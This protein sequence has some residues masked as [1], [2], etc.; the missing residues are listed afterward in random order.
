LVGARRDVG[1]AVSCTVGKDRAVPAPNLATTT[2]VTVVIAARNAADTVSA[3]V[4]SA[5]ASPLVIQCVVV[6]DA[7]DD[8]TAESA[9]RAGGTDGRLQ[10][11]RR[12]ERGGP[13]RARNDGLVTAH[14]GTVCFLDADDALLAGGLEQLAAGLAARRGAVA[15]LGRFRAVDAARAPVDVGSWAV[16]QLRPVL[17]R[18]GAMVASPEGMVPEALVSRL[19]S[20]PPGAWLVDA[21]TARALGGFDPRARRSEDVELLV[22]LAAAGPIVCVDREVLEYRRHAAQRSAAHARRRWGRGHTMW[23][24]LR[25]SPGATSTIALAR[26][27]A[28]YHLDL[29]AARRGAPTLAV[30]AMAARNLVLAGVMRVLGAAAAVLPRHLRDPLGVPATGAVD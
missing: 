9:T 5:L 16:N 27:M 21:G 18:T 2:G 30:R 17:R 8:D 23:L 25:A 10:V 4:R 24:M 29:F 26:G 7:S 19:V 28:A 11:V 20:P 14:A 15:A 1:H 6:D 3:A 22:R 13:A 12:S